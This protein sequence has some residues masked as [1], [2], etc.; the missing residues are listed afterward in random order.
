MFPHFKMKIR[1]FA[2]MP[3]VLPALLIGMI[4]TISAQTITT[5]AGNGTASFSGDAGQ[6]ASAGLNTPKGLAVAPNGTVYIADEM[7]FRVRT[8]SVPG[9]ISTFAG[10]GA[11]TF[12]GDGG[13]ASGSSL[14]DVLA[15]AID[16]SGNVYIADRS[17]RR[18]RKVSTSGVITTIAGTGVEGY[19]GD[20]GPAVNAQIGVPT[21]LAFDP[22]GN[23]YFTDT[24]PSAMRVRRISASG[25]ITTVAGN[26]VVGYAGDGQ[27]ALAAALSFPLGISF[28]QAGNFYIADTGNNVIRKVSAASIITTV[29]GTG[30]ASFSGDGGAATSATLN[31]PSDVQFDLAGN[32]YIADAG[33]NRVR[34]VDTTGKI[35]T[36]AGTGA[37][38]FSGDNGAAVSAALNHPWSLAIDANNAIYIADDLNNRIRVIAGATPSQPVLAPSSAVNAASFAK[39]QPVAPGSYVAIFGSSFSTQQGISALATPLPTALG[40]TSV[41][42]NGA[43]VPLNFV[44][45]G[46]INVQIPFNTPVGTANL[47]INR[48]NLSS[49][50]QLLG[51]ATYSPGIFPGVAANGGTV[52]HSNF[53][54]VTAAA[55]AKAGEILI[56]YATGLGP[57]DA[58]IGPGQPAPSAT[59]VNTL[60][61]PVVTMGTANAALSFSGLAPNL[62]AVYQVNFQV[63]TN[64]TPGNY[65]LTFTSGG[66]VSNAVVVPVQ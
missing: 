19:T 59:L 15:V 3:V 27:S 55:P 60:Q 35:T 5:L 25:T 8:V 43:A 30:A 62:V 22:S 10:N 28:D 41:L 24:S 17:N 48:G 46:Q 39:N 26:G 33:N 44:S 2:A 52:F 38:S 9:I 21:A 14:S 20:N 31:L 1:L 29:A 64:M 32:M 56:V 53:S 57:V 23:L 6:A 54:Y 65:N 4:G 51:I 36:I 11:N 40:N 34:R 45:P 16:G 12:A 63:P 66:V 18:I 42:V 58:A 13:Q 37:G 47:Q 50:V 61:N 7:N 49:A